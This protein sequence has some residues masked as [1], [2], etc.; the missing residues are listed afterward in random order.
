MLHEITKRHVLYHVI[1]HYSC[2]G[3]K[4]C[5]QLNN[6]DDGYHRYYKDEQNS[7]KITFYGRNNRQ[8]HKYIDSTSKS[9]NNENEQWDYSGETLYVTHIREPIARAISHYKYSERWSCNEQL[10]KNRN[11]LYQYKNNNMDPKQIPLHKL[12]FIPT[13]DNERASFN[14]FMYELY[15]NSDKKASKLWSCSTN[16]FSRWIT[17]MYHPQDA[18]NI[19]NTTLFNITYPNSEYYN[20]NNNNTQ[21]DKLTNFGHILKEESYKLFYRY[22]LITVLEWLRDDPIYARSTEDMYFNSVRGLS[23]LFSSAAD[24][25]GIK[26]QPAYISCDRE[27]KLAN[28]ILPMEEIS[29]KTKYIMEKRNDIDINLYNTLTTC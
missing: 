2:E 26:K 12:N 6:Y 22:D 10:L 5:L 9:Y 27:S 13:K 23:T 25:G 7:T 24:G 4:Q 20:N 14:G 21:Q 15:Y 16:C 3:G 17:G 11:F 18:D 8:K 28:Y 1:L 29:D 19:R